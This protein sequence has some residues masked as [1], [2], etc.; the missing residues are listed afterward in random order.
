MWIVGDAAMS[1]QEHFQDVIDI[2]RD[3]HSPAPHT[4][5][6]NMVDV[7]KC[8]A[9]E[10][11]KANSPLRISRMSNDI[12]GAGLFKRTQATLQNYMAESGR[13]M[14]RDAGSK[15][16]KEIIEAAKSIPK[17]LDENFEGVFSDFRMPF[18]IKAT[19]LL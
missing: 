15:I 13:A 9:A 8:C 17:S 16:E 12:Q 6:L 5:V 11:G 2:S 10:T 7:F 1:S 18:L 3:S 14:F 4:I 19:K